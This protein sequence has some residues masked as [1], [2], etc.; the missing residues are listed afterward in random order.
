MTRQ[1]KTVFYVVDRIEGRFAVLAGDDGRQL[2]FVRKDLPKRAKEGSVLRVTVSAGGVPDF[3]AA[4]V[5]EEERK[6]RRD[7]ARRA[8]DELAAGDPGGDVAL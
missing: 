5:D 6:R 2:D 4:V 1:E 8:V 7:E 3:R